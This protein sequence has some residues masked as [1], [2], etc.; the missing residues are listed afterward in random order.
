MFVKKEPLLPTEEEQIVTDTIACGM[1]VHRELGPG[2]RERI[3]ET[4]FRLE[5]EARNMKFVSEK[6]IDVRYKTWLIP[7]QIIDLVVE[8]VVLV[9]LKAVNRLKEVHVSQVLSY[10][11]TT[12]LRVGLL[13]NFNST[14][15]K[16]GLRRIVR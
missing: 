15:L 12:G 5:L 13:M 9:E 1:A 8:G 2:F 7:G 3:Y 11:K 14:R 4:A 10:L 16:D 6:K